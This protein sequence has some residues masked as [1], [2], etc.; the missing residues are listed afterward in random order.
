[1]RG[2]IIAI[3]TRRADANRAPQSR[4]TIASSQL[5]IKVRGH[6]R[7][8][9]SRSRRAH[10]TPVQATTAPSRAYAIARRSMPRPQQVA[11]TQ[12]RAS[13]SKDCTKS[14]VRNRA[15]V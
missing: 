8:Q 3:A 14:R 15:P 9:R 11:R 6:N 1:V 7:A 13:P 5:Q 2:A 4:T 10:S 12:S